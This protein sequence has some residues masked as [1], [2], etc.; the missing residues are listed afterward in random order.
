MGKREYPIGKLRIKVN[1]R[2]ILDGY[3]PVEL[4]HRRQMGDRAF[5]LEYREDSPYTVHL[6]FNDHRSRTNQYG[7]GDNVA[8]D[9]V[10]G[11]KI[12]GQ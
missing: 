7:K 6:T 12:V 4:R 10:Q 3:E 2:Q 5:E 11:D 8:G 9:R 1:L